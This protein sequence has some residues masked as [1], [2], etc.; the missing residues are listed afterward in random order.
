[1]ILSQKLIFKPKFTK[2]NVASTISM[3]E[4]LSKLNLNKSFSFFILHKGSKNLELES[5]EVSCY[6]DHQELERLF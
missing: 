6:M 2:I 1:M 3:E 4:N 5:E